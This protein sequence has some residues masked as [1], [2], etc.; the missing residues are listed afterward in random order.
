MF[1]LHDDALAGGRLLVVAQ[2]LYRWQKLDMFVTLKVCTRCQRKCLNSVANDCKLA[3]SLAA[4]LALLVALLLTGLSIQ[5][6]AIMPLNNNSG[7][8]VTDNF[9][10]FATA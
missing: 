8:R 7:V 1:S 9:C 5:R 2:L 6:Y 10:V 4:C 3:L